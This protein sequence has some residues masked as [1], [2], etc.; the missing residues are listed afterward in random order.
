MLGMTPDELGL[1]LTLG[2][3]VVFLFVVTGI[4]CRLRR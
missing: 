4:A 2:L 3:A 1:L